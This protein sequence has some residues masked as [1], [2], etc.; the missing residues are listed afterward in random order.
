M[1]P[2]ADGNG[3]RPESSWSGVGWVSQ[4]PLGQIRTRALAHSGIPT[5]TLPLLSWFK[6]ILVT[7]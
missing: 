7:H 3:G 5:A 1:G 6:C 4:G 2:P